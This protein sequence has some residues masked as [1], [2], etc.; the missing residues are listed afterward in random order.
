VAVI[1]V[2]S[3]LSSATSA[4]EV[5]SSFRTAMAISAVIALVAAPVCFVGLG[6]RALARRSARDTYCSVDGPPLLPD[7]ERCPASVDR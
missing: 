1:P 6:P 7:P 3:G 4:S 5:T 2:A